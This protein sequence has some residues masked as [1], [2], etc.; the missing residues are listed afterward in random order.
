MNARVWIDAARPKTLGASIA[1]V[2]LG[3][4]LASRSQHHDPFITVLI[5]VA[6]LAIQVG[7]NFCNDYCD[8]RRGADL[9]R[10]GPIRATQAGLVSP[11]A[12]KIAATRAFV[13][14]VIVGT[15]LVWRG[16]VPI[17][18]IGLMSIACGA[19]YTAGPYPLAY[20][21][22]GDLFVLIFFGPIAVAGTYYLHARAWSQEA[23]VL[24]LMPGFLSVAILV[25]N[26]LRDRESDRIARKRTLVVLFGE[27]FGRLEYALC[28]AISAAIILYFQQ[29]LGV[30]G[31]LCVITIL[32]GG[33]FVL[34]LGVLNSR[35]SDLNRLLPAT[36]MLL[37]VT[38]LLTAIF[39]VHP[40]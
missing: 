26:N 15:L 7:T 16:G 36:N 20:I 13:L 40:V 8:W 31:A 39:L 18:A 25:V 28:L 35:G 24:G 38:S 33:G 10:V 12:M 23:W 19:L 1:P 27:K 14:A 3:S 30:I 37:L 9:N 34:T 2:L 11:Q 22:M 17:L 6:A 21:G 32:V 4:A 5:L 29:T